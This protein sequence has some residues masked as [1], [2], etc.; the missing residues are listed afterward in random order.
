M[1]YI[2]PIYGGVTRMSGLSGL[3]VDGLVFSLMQLE[4]ARVDKVY[5]DRQL[6]LWKQEQYREITSALQSFQN[7]YFNLLKP[8]TDMRKQGYIQRFRG[9]I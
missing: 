2:N 7:E 1:S 4:R 8:A 5:Q 3:D 9:E 6:L